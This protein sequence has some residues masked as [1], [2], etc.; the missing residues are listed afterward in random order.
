[1]VQ[2]LDWKSPI[3]KVGFCCGL[4]E[5][6]IV[7]GSPAVISVGLTRFYPILVHLHSDWVMTDAHEEHSIWLS[8]YGII[9]HSTVTHATHVLRTLMRSSSA[10]TQTQVSQH[11]SSATKL[12]PPLTG[13]VPLYT[14][15]STWQLPIYHAKHVLI[16]TNLPVWKP[17]KGSH[18]CQQALSVSHTSSTI[19][20]LRQFGVPGIWSYFYS[21]LSVQRCFL[22]VNVQ[23]L[24]VPPVCLYGILVS[25]IL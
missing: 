25:S 8:I 11:N 13:S 2:W 9:M 7:P 22:Y 6:V 18:I 12:A 4:N 5:S 21:S 23:E 15:C 17:F 10:K 3:F 14:S 24:I 16:Q 19:L 20:P 1:M